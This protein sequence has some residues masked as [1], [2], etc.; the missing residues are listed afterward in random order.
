MSWL[1]RVRTN[2]LLREV[3][4]LSEYTASA[5]G[6]R[7]AK[8]LDRLGELLYQGADRAEAL[9]KESAQ[10]ADRL[11]RRGAVAGLGLGITVGMAS[12]PVQ[13]ALAGVTFPALPGWVAVVVGFGLVVIIGLVTHYGVYV[14]FDDVERPFRAPRIAARLAFL[15]FLAFCLSLGVVIVTLRTTDP[16]AAEWL[17][18][19]AAPSVWVTAEFGAIAA[20]LLMAASWPSFATV[21]ADRQ[22]R[23]LC[24]DVRQLVAA[25]DDVI[26]RYL[27]ET[28]TDKWDSAKRRVRDAGLLKGTTE[29]DPNDPL[30]PGHGGNVPPGGRSLDVFV[31]A[32]MAGSV[33]ACSPTTHERAYGPAATAALVA[34]A[35]TATPRRPGTAGGDTDRSCGVLI[36]GTLSGDRHH[37][38]AALEVI[39][40]RLGTFVSAARCR[41]LLTATFAAAGPFTIFKYFE[42]PAPPRLDSCGESL[43]PLQGVKRIF[44]QAVGQ[45]KVYLDR[46]QLVVAACRKQRDKTVTDFEARVRSVLDRV[47]TSILGSVPLEVRTDSDIIG[48]LEA[49]LVDPGGY[50]VLSDGVDTGTKRLRLQIPAGAFV[51]LALIPS[52][53]EFGGAEAARA[54]ALRWS[55]TKRLVVVGWPRLA[56]PNAFEAI[57]ASIR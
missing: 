25:G 50:L 17:S 51:V 29:D 37:R 41:Q 10:A 31:I 38:R 42:L 20:G 34:P 39:A 45:R 32:L 22:L 23:S 19:F 28:A 43:P 13:A 9:P 54:A 16:S 35:P 30:G 26:H 18:T 55:K 11:P 33:I 12:V 24:H 15:A 6:E 8:L 21:L 27:A 7:A 53:P 4:G 56:A 14:A 47:K 1:F 48:V 57:V 2:H 5:V 46:H 40:S 52:S 49:A 3:R 36:D 44:G